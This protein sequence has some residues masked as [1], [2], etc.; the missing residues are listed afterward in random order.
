MERPKY[1]ACIY[2]Q[3]RGNIYIPIDKCR[4]QALKD[5]YILIVMVL[6]QQIDYYKRISDVFWLGDNLNSK[7]KYHMS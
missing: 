7:K 2:Q 5:K 3:R 6:W 1:I 4:E